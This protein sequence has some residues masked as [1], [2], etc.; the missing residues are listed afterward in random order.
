[1]P[2]VVTLEDPWKQNE[3]DVSSIPTGAYFCQRGLHQLR[4]GSPV[5][6]TFEVTKVLGRTGILF[7]KGNTQVDTRGCILVGESFEL[8]QGVPGILASGKGFG[9]FM[10]KF[11]GET[12]FQLLIKWA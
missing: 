12:A 3:V 1:M 9:E 7:H 8:I 10:E 5:F 2:F 6:E 11:V 4:P